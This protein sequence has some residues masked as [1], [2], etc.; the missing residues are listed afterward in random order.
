MG[1]KWIY[2]LTA[3]AVSEPEANNNEGSSL[4]E[5][6]RAKRRIQVFG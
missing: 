3:A 4:I 5:G 2:L 6:F 1:K